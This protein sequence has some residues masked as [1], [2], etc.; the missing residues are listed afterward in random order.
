[1]PEAA[2]LEGEGGTRGRLSSLLHKVEIRMVK[3]NLKATCPNL[4]KFWCA[5]APGAGWEALGCLRGCLQEGLTD[6]LN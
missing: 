4:A 6:V 2:G 5:T 1:M 3:P